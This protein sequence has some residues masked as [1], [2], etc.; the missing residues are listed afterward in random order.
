MSPVFAAEFPS[1]ILFVHASSGPAFLCRRWCS[2]KRQNWKYSVSTSHTLTFRE[3]RECVPPVS[4]WIRSP[5]QIRLWF[6][7]SRRSFILL[8]NP[9]L[10]GETL[11]R[12]SSHRLCGPNS[13]KRLFGIWKTSSKEVL[14][15]LPPPK[16]LKRLSKIKSMTLWQK[17]SHF[18]FNVPKRTVW[19]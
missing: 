6:R 18:H 12:D 15:R 2:K 13:L 8:L 9:H 14:Q 3:G 19:I 4:R 1:F 7:G 16:N 10:T 11:T 17:K 5:D